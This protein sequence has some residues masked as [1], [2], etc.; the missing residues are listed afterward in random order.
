MGIRNS[1]AGALPALIAAQGQLLASAHARGIN[2]DIADF[3]GVRTFADTV[4][5]IGYRAAEYAAAVANNPSL[6][7]TPINTWRPIAPF[8]QSMHNYGAAFDVKITKA[9]PGM[10][11][12]SALSQLKTLAPSVGLR[13]NVPND[14]PHFE[15]PITLEQAKALWESQGNA[16]PGIVQ[17]LT[18][19]NAVAASTVALIVVTFVAL[20]AFRRRS[21]GR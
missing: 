13:S 3:G 8:G 10:S 15:L 17:V 11:F 4:V 19:S 7:N 14:P 21:V 18:T 12:D 9:P 1:I 2:F 16:S 6:A 20:A 5:I